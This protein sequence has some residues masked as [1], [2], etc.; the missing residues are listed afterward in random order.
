[1][2]LAAEVSFGEF[3][4]HKYT[5]MPTPRYSDSDQTIFICNRLPGVS[6]TL[7]ALEAPPLSCGI[8]HVEKYFLVLYLTPYVFPVWINCIK[9][10]LNNW[11]TFQTPH[12]CHGWGLFP[13]AA[14]DFLLHVLHGVATLWLVQ[15]TEGSKIMLGNQKTWKPCCELIHFELFGDNFICWS[16]LNHRVSLS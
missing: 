9:L 11:R 2:G 14:S 1:V 5:R 6:G 7:P 15:E 12:R 4:K 10:L 8:S 3:T 13:A 16:V